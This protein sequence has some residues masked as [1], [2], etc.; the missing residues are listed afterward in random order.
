MWKVVHLRCFSYVDLVCKISMRNSIS[1]LIPSLSSSPKE[2][3]ITYYLDLILRQ[4]EAFAKIFLPD[5]VKT[6][7]KIDFS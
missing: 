4:Y 7:N 1:N 2:V 5:M 6:R 3:W